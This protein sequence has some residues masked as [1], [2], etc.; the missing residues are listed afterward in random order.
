MADQMFQ[1]RGVARYPWLNKP[2]TKFDAAGK[3]KVDLEIT[4]ED[5]SKLLPS[6]EKIREQTKADFQ[7]SAKGKK[8]KNADLPLAPQLDNEGNETGSFIL[9]VGMKAS[10][11][12]KKT[13]KPWTRAVPIFDAKGKP[14]NPQIFGGSELIVSFKA[15]GWSNPKGECGT[16]C[17][18]E[19]VQVLKLSS[20]GGGSASAAGLGFT[21]QEGYSAE[22]DEV[23][24]DEAGEDQASG[25]YDFE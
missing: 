25:A 24:N 5:A 23:T 17:Y 8:A 22:D 12:S 1:A 4:A 11:V 6:L 14:A 15:Q 21:A 13:G 9:R 10:G 19:G 20:G 3:Y 2:D 7:K 18:L 16:T